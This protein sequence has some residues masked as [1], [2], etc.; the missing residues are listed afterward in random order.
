MD[1]ESYHYTD[2]LFLL[3]HLLLCPKKVPRMLQDG[4]FSSNTY[5]SSLAAVPN[6][7]CAHVAE[8]DEM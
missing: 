8:C 4:R 3:K 5:V 6:R 7:V 1:P 2:V